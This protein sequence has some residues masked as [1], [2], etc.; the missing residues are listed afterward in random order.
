MS[1]AN[2]ELWPVLDW[3]E[4]RA[5]QRLVLGSAFSQSIRQKFNCH[6]IPT[7][8][9]PKY[10]KTFPVIHLLYQG[11]SQFNLLRQNEPWLTDFFLGD[12]FLT[13]G[14]FVTGLLNI[15]KGRFQDP[16]RAGPLKG[17]LD[18][19]L[20]FASA[21]P[22]LKTFATSTEV[23][24][25][26]AEAFVRCK[27]NYHSNK[28]LTVPIRDLDPEG[29]TAVVVHTATMYKKTRFR[30]ALVRSKHRPVPISFF[31]GEPCELEV[32]DLKGFVELTAP[33]YAGDL[34][35]VLSEL[36]TWGQT[37]D[38]IVSKLSAD[39]TILTLKAFAEKI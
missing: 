16:H 12:A 22:S 23:S 19:P 33:E 5:R 11:T 34:I 35:P 6:P 30:V 39:E 24:P 18:V 15:I 17:E 20:A 13:P 25:V 3:A 27:G 32:V 28:E 31:R 10:W 21:P 2:A 37:G 38:K 1:Q 9:D 36:T 26:P 7:A 8:V 4:I 14:R 29:W